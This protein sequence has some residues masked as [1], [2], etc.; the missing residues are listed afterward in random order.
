MLN[1]KNKWQFKDKALPLELQARHLDHHIQCPTATVAVV[2]MHKS[3]KMTCRNQAVKTGWQRPLLLLQNLH[4]AHKHPHNPLSSCCC[5]LL[6]T[7]NVPIHLDASSSQSKPLSQLQDHHSPLLRL[8]LRFLSCFN[9]ALLPNFNRW[10]T[11]INCHGSLAILWRPT[12]CTYNFAHLAY[13]TGSGGKHIHAEWCGADNTS[14][15]MTLTHSFFHAF[16]H[17]SFKQSFICSYDYPF[18]QNTNTGHGL[19][20]PYSHK[21]HMHT[22][23]C[24]FNFILLIACRVHRT[25]HTAAHEFQ[26]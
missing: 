9:G 4:I 14:Q 22:V 24:M 23:D 5:S 17:Y 11:D 6:V 20:N 12:H 2:V 19:S 3:L 13:Y 7:S 26:T 18:Y 10:S 8:R 16:I 1:L 21:V 15:G 25:C